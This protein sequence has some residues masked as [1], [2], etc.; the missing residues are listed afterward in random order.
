VPAP[1][2]RSYG[3]STRSRD[4]ELVC[5][6]FPKQLAE[7]ERKRL[8]GEQLERRADSPI[9]PLRI[10][11]RSPRRSSAEVLRELAA[12]VGRDDLAA[13]L[14]AAGRR[15]RRSRPTSRSP[16]RVRAPRGRPSSAGF[17]PHSDEPHAEQRARL[18]DG[19]SRG[20]ASRGAH[21]DQHP[22]RRRSTRSGRLGGKTGLRHLF[23]AMLSRCRR[24]WRPFGGIYGT[25]DYEGHAAIRRRRR[26][27]RRRRR[28]RG[29]VLGD[30]TPARGST[31]R[32]TTPS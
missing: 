2:R 29:A 13:R 8:E 7:R 28:R 25:G 14:E 31:T 15:R 30:D 16:R 26:P 20:G 11:T 10:S 21:A 24:A 1:R 23:R 12:D 18:A 22:C 32:R 17:D 6:P 19:R 3:R 4:G 9:R 27:G 5:G